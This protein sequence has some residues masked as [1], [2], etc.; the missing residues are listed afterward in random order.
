ME[1]LSINLNWDLAGKDFEPGKFSPDHMIFVNDDISMPSSAAPD[2]GGNKNS[3][4]PEQGL[5]ASISSCH[6]M[7]F[8]ALAAK[9]KW[10][11]KTYKDTAVAKLGKN[12]KGLMSGTEIEL[13]PKVEFSNGFS[14][15]NLKMKEVQDRAHRYCFISNSLSKEVKV[16]INKFMNGSMNNQLVKTS[17]HSNCILRIT[18]N[19]PSQH[20]VLSEEMMSA[21]QSVLDKS[22]NDKS[23]R[24]II[25]SAEG[26]TFSAGHDLKQL[27][28]GRDNSDKGRDYFKKVMLKCSKLMQSIINNPKPIIAEVSGTATAA[29]CQLVASCDLAYAGTS[30]RFATPGV[31]IGLFCS[32]PMV[33]LSR[34][35]SNKHSMEMLLNGDL[36]SSKKAAEIG[37]IN[38]VVNDNDLES[39]VLEKALKI[40]KKS[41]MTLKIGKQAFYNQIN[42]NL[43]EA[44]DYAS[45]VMVEN[46]LKIDA[47]EG[48]DAFINKRNPNWQDK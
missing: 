47:E 43:S 8:L 48:I 17:I 6:M 21:I 30:S 27:K 44:Y 7:T 18:L 12:L 2:Y 16:K 4:N 40:S 31:N 35:V 25:I 37:L 22:V 1:E 14:V 23:I 10:P 15:D 3:L 28:K 34:T 19:N 39:I 46:M 29:G 38:E 36:I 41:A 24:V 5:A 20:N 33:A 45:N 32:T 9:M 13:N 42:M 11:V 26:K